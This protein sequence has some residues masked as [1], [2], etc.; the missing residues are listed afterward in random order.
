MNAVFP[1]QSIYIFPQFFVTLFQ[2][3]SRRT[4]RRLPGNILLLRSVHF[5]QTGQLF[6]IG[7]HELLQFFLGQIFILFAFA[8]FLF[9]TFY[10]ALLMQFYYIIKKFFQK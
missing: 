5:I 1:L 3:L 4:G 6:F 9:H 10:L 7:S 2:Q 8:F